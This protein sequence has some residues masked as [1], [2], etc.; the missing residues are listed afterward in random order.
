MEQKDY[1][2]AAIM[3]TDIAGFSRM[4]ERDE[5]GTLDLLR[6]HNQLIGGIVGAHHGAIIK[7]IGDAL[8]VDF[9]NT[10][11]AMQS[12]L[13]IQDKLYAHNKESPDLPLLVRIGVHLG[14]IYFFENDALGEGINIAARLQSLARP[15][16]I[17][18]SQDVYNLVLN[19]IEFRAEKL[20]KVSLKNITKEIHAYEITTPNVEFDADRDKPRSGYKPGS[21][22]DNGQR[23]TAEDEAAAAETAGAVMAT[24]HAPAPH[25]AQPVV[26]APPEAGLSAAPPEASAPRAEPERSYSPEGSRQVI[27]EIRTAILQAIK[28]EGRRL[29]VNEALAR[30]GS[31]GVEAREV[32]AAL[33][34]E[35]ILQRSPRKPD[36]SGGQD[37]DSPYS[38]FGMGPRGFDGEALGRNIEAAVKG[39]VSEIERNAAGHGANSFDAERIREKI[40][41]HE[42]KRE[43]HRERHEIKDAIRAGLDDLPT[44]KWDVKLKEKDEWNPG[45]EERSSDFDSY[46]DQLKARARRQRGGLIGNFTSFLAVNAG[47]FFLYFT[48]YPHYLWAPIVAASWGIGVVSSLVAAVRGG[49]KAREAKAMPDLDGRQL[50]IY[51][52]LNRVKD[53]MAMHTA[54]TFTVPILL[55]LINFAYPGGSHFLWFLIPTVAMVISF[56][57]HLGSYGSSQGKLRRELMSSLGVEGGWRNIFRTGRARRAMGT[58]LGPYAAQY[59][60]AERAKDAILAESKSGSPLDADLGPTLQSYVGQIKV[61]AQSANEIDRIIGAIPMGDLG[62]DKAELLAKAETAGSAALKEEY[63]RSVEEI[64]K[65]EKSYGEL[66]NQSEMIKLRLS[67]SVNQLKQMRIDM[68]RLKAAGEDGAGGVGGV[69]ELKRRAGELTAY[70]QDLRKGYSESGADPYAELE[71]IERANEERKRLIDEGDAPQS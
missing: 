12:A 60:D 63:R 65:Q 42:R 6:Y 58:E 8:L 33:V 25:R 44:S 2:L 4:M 27:S 1:R 41:R 9:K 11:E 13:E 71:E 47:L 29:T 54:S 64:D 16:C 39:F 56:I 43:R 32:I 50:G 59:Q 57:S 68:A 19:K 69:G 62:H 36:E 3:Y 28:T 34:D 40:E 5:A 22:L 35:G 52:K 17:C 23:E 20:G 31:Y 37:S 61:L 49:A 30:Y 48:Y 55:G 14:D 26:P 51:K 15:G 46:R 7:T 10:V 18:F 70:I 24:S 38:F 21:Y 45:G 67:S 53:S 66:R